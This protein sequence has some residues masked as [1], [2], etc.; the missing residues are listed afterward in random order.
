MSTN[1]ALFVLI[2]SAVFV[3]ILNAGHQP[4]TEV[5]LDYYC[6]GVICHGHGFWQATPG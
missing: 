2:Y 1:G 6:A 4:P 3:L 5:G